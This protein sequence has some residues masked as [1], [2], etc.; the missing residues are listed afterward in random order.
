MKLSTRLLLGTTAALFAGALGVAQI[1]RL[2]LSQMVAQTDGAIYGTI[3]DSEVIRIDHPIDGPELYYTTLFIEGRVLGSSR[4]ST[5]GVTF[6]GGF[7]DEQHGVWNSEAPSADEIRIGNRVLA[8]YK[9]SDNMGGDLA[10]NAL[11]AAHGGL[12]STL[13]AGGQTIIQGRGDGYAVREN[14]TITTL[15]ERVAVIRQSQK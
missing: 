5:V 4:T 14:A 3:V 13:Q 8:F 2:D 12:Y 9:W 6:A 1:V 10:G 7:I 11:Y 15:E